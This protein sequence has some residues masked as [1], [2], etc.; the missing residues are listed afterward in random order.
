MQVPEGGQVNVGNVVKTV[1]GAAWRLYVSHRD[2]YL[3]I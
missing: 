2:F 3:K 1:Q